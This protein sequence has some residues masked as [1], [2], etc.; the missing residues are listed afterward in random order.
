LKQLSTPWLEQTVWLHLLFNVRPEFGKMGGAKIM[1]T[2]CNLTGWGFSIFGRVVFV[3]LF[4]V[5]A[6]AEDFTNVLARAVLAEQRDDLSAAV[7]IYRQVE[8]LEASNAV[9]LCRLSRAYCDLMYL[10]RSTAVQTN[11][12]GHALACA[13]K[14]VRLDPQDALAHVCVAV[15]YAKNCSF[16]SIKARVADSRLFKNE[17]EVALRLDPRQDV[18]YYLLGRWEYAIANLNFV[19]R[20]FVKIAYGGLPAASNEQAIACLKTAIRLAPRC[21]LYRADLAKVYKTVG[22]EQLA[23]QELAECV[24]LKPLDRDDAD[25]QKEAVKMLGR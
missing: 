1:M 2:R 22:Q 15:C 20:G 13:L 4:S 9:N 17:A 7:M 14:A 18:A 11:L 5:T 23:Q 3:L 16:V 8:P 25:A 6:R 12:L 24:R 10:N 21:I 19:S